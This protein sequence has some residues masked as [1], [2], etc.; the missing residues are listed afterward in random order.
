MPV[1]TRVL[2]VGG[3]LNGLTAATLLAHHGVQCMVVERH[4]GT[5]IQYKFAGISP[6]SMEIFRS[7]GLEEEIRLHKYRRS[8]GWRDRTRQKPVRSRAAM[9]RGGVAGRESVQPHTA[10]DMRPACARTDLAPACRSPRGGYPFRYRVHILR[11]GSDR[12][13]GENHGS[14]QRYRGIGQCGLSHRRRRRRRHAARPARHRPAR[15]GRAAALDEHHLRH[16]YVG[17]DRRQ[18]L[19]LMFCH[20][21]QRDRHAASGRA[22]AA[23]AAIFPGKGRDG[24]KTS[25]P[26]V[27]GHWCGQPPDG[28]CGQTSSTRVPGQLLRRW[29]TVSGKAAPS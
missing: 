21:A 2:I 25:T 29:P 12:G 26:N 17:R 4:P 19:H 16:R 7:V 22:L 3:G 24:R 5:S 11:A 1:N 27:R 10:G 23:C 14:S 13:P 8:A 20:R 15:P 6:R 9:E 28:R 18:A